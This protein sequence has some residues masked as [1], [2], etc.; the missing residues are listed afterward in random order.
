LHGHL[1]RNKGSG[2]RAP[3]ARRRQQVGLVLFHTGAGPH[4]VFLL[5]KAHS[6]I[7]RLRG[8]M[9]DNGESAD[10]TI[11]IADMIS[12][13]NGAMGWEDDRSAYTAARDHL[14]Q[15]VVRRRPSLDQDDDDDG[16]HY[17]EQEEEEEKKM[18]G[19]PT[20]TG[21]GAHLPCSWDRPILKARIE[22]A[23]LTVQQ[24]MQGPLHELPS[25]SSNAKIGALGWCFGGHSILEM[26]RHFPHH[27]GVNCAV[28]FHG[29]LDG[30]Q[31]LGP[32]PGDT[33]HFGS[34]SSSS[35]SSAFR[36][37]LCNGKEDPFVKRMQLSYYQ[38]HILKD[39][40]C[41]NNNIQWK[42]LNFDHVRHGFTN[43]AQV[44]HPNQATFGYDEEAANES[45]E[46]AIATLRQSLLL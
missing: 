37:L 2:R 8:S 5:W 18:E 11:L 17:Y 15:K 4:D 42:L 16:G 21:A 1:I 26:T 12:D 22:A 23:V 9:E 30:I 29:V 7:Q 39:R 43:P 41:G 25:P 32:V 13:S 40:M 34:F 35:S 19:N 27:L 31:E 28:S 3:S 46:A 45:W 14:L 20:M 38:N 33:K 36:L 10:V 24:H 6:L 44:H